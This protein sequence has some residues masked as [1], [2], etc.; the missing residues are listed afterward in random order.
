MKALEMVSSSQHRLRGHQSFGSEN[1]YIFLAM[2]VILLPLRTATCCPGF[3][4][5]PK[6]K[7]YI[8]GRRLARSV[9][10]GSPV[11]AEDLL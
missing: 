3:G 11:L 8:V 10:A 6:F 1:H 5:L 2:R 9:E 4:L 7:D